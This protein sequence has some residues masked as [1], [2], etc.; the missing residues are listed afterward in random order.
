MR[1]RH[2]P[3]RGEQ[4]RAARYAHKTRADR[5]SRHAPF[6]GQRGIIAPV[7]ATLDPHRPS[8]PPNFKTLPALARGKNLLRRRTPQAEYF[9][10]HKYAVRRKINARGHRRARALKYN[11]LLRKPFQFRPRSDYQILPHAGSL[12]YAAIKLAG[13]GRRQQG[14]PAFFHAHIN[15]QTVTR[16]YPPWRMQYVSMANTAL[17]RVK[18]PLYL[19]RPLMT[20]GGEHGARLHPSKAQP[21]L[22]LPAFRLRRRRS[23]P[24]GALRR[25]THRPANNQTPA[26]ARLTPP[27]RNNRVGHW[28]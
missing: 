6:R 27:R 13:G 2:I 24:F 3:Q 15:R 4:L 5:A 18:Y 25:F 14:L 17:F 28:Y 9:P 16:H 21:Q 8:R 22:G 26:A 12:P 11:I 19:Q 7:L 10:T 1:T 23:H 20:A